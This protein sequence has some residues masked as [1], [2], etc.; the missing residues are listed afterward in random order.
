[1]SVIEKLNHYRKKYQYYL[2][3]NSMCIFVMIVSFFICA[4]NEKIGLI[5]LLVTIIAMIFLGSSAAKSN[6]IFR[7]VYKAVFVKNMLCK[8]FDDVNYDWKR[9]FTGP[10]MYDFHL[11]NYKEHTSD[12]YLEASYKGISFKMADIV[13]THFHG[14]NNI[15][16]IKGKVISIKHTFAK[17]D[18]LWVYTKKYE[19][20]NMYCKKIQRLAMVDDKKIDSLFYVYTLDKMDANK[21]ITAEI[22]ERLLL[23]RSKYDKFGICFNGNSVN[24]VIESSKDTFDIDVKSKKVIK[25]VEEERIEQDITGIIEVIE[26]L[27]K[28]KTVN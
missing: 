28:T 20:D 13:H 24:I 8:K 11:F 14:K 22:R 2:M 3:L 21:L 17:V 27:G 7:A 18:G 12:D 5:T 16:I 26:I 9:G 25:E 15:E 1:M 23:L 19:H 6:R 4:V 10:E